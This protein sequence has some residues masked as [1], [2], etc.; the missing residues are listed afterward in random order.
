MKRFSVPLPPRALKNL[1]RL[2]KLLCE[3]S[4]EKT[5][6]RLLETHLGKLS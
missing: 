3:S 1:K 5:L 4:L 2:Q 6:M